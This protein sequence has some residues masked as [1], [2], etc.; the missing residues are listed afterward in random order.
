MGPK[1]ESSER[2]L[3]ASSHHSGLPTIMVTPP[4]DVLLI[5]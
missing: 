4:F 3:F 5:H 1:D 2:I